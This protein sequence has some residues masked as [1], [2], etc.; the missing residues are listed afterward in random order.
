MK[1]KEEV[2]VEA[3][4]G[5]ESSKNIVKILF[6]IVVICSCIFCTYT[7]RNLMKYSDMDKGITP[8]QLSEIDD[9]HIEEITVYINGTEYTSLEEI[10]GVS[11]GDIVDCKVVLSSGDTET[12]K[13]YIVFDNDYH[14]E[15]NNGTI[16]ISI[17]EK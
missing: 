15:Y 4:K 3:N 8:E 11:A 9:N 2:F 10:E 12:T 16:K 7:M 5:T 1:D 6:V 13:G 17:K 14:C